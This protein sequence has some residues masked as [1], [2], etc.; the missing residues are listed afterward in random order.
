MSDH[1]VRWLSRGLPT[2]MHAAQSEGDASPSGLCNT[3]GRSGITATR[4]RSAVRRFRWLLLAG[5]IFAGA[6]FAQSADMVLAQHVVTPDPV[7]AGGVA[8]IT[9]T[10]NNNGTS[11]AANVQLTDTI[12]A[13]STFVSMTASNG[14]TCTAVA[15]YVCTWATIPFPGSRTVTLRVTLPTAAVWTNSAALTSDTADNNT[16]NNSL[17]R[18]ITVV[19]AANLAVSATSS[20]GGP[21]AAGT[22]YNYAVTVTNNG[23]PDPLPAGQSPRVT[24]NVPTG[25][26]VTSRPTG[27]GWDCQPSSGYPLTAPAG[28]GAGTEIT[29]SRSDGLASGASFPNI[30]VPAVANV[31]GSVDATFDVRSNFPDG[32]TSDNVDTETVTLTA[33]TDMAI[34]K[35]AALAAGGGGSQATF[36]LAA[37]QLGGSPPTGVTVTDTLPAGLDYVSHSAAAPWVCDFGAT[38]AGRLTCT[39]PGTYIGGPFT[40][41][42]AI[43]LVANVSGI[44]DIPNTGTVAANEADSN[45]ANN[46]ST[47]TVNNSADLRISKSPSVNPVVTGAS[48]DWNIVVRNF[49]PMPVLTGQ[50][51]T[52]TETVPAGMSLAALPGGSQWSCA[53]LPAVGPTTVTCTH[54]RSS[55]LAVNSD[56]PTLSIPATNTNAG[57]L[58]NNVCLALSGGGP[59]EAGDTP[60]F[61]RNCVGAGITGTTGVNSADLQIVKNASPGSVVVGQNLTYT[62]VATNLS[63]TVDATNVHVYDTVNNLVSTG[64]LQSITTTQG[65]CSPAGPYPLNGVSQ[66]VDC[67][68]G[69]L[70]RNGGSATIVIT[71]RPNNATAAVLARGN[72]ATVNSLDVGDPDRSN[73]SSTVSSNVEP[74]VDATVTKTVNPSSNVRVGQPTVYTVTARNGGPSRANELI[75]TDVM[76]PNT[77]FVSVGT[78]SNSGTCSTVPAVNAVGGTLSCRWTNVDAN[79][80]RT[81]T[82]TVRPLAAALGTTISNTVNVTVGAGD[83]E[84][85]TTN[86]SSTITTNVIDSLVDIL[87]QKTDS[88]D[89]VALGAETMYTVTIRNAGPSIG[90]NLVMTD[91]F[92]NAGNTARFSY[93]GSL[94]ATVAGVNVPAPACTAPAIGAMSGTLQCTF[95]TIDVGTTEQ[96]VLTYRMRA[97]SIITAGS[98]SGTQGNRVTVAVAENETQTTNNTVDED[99]TTSR[100]APAAGSEIDLGI[101][102]TTSAARATPG[103]E[104]DYTLRVTNTQTAGSGRDVVPANGAQVTDALPAGLTF[105]SAPG[106]SYD[107]ASR[108]VVCVIASLAA[109]ASVDFTVR[110]RVDSPYAGPA[111]LSNTACVDMPADPVGG[112]NC[113]TTPKT[114]GTPPPT[115]IP[116]LSEWGMIL[117]SILLA[118]LALREV[119]LQRRR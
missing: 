102:K 114:V 88:V 70:L 38:V 93:Q 34:T 21:I 99:T 92:P 49:G 37:R 110:V 75:I 71:V 17:T 107:G 98:Y 67:D 90:T 31:T 63:T 80:N 36:T 23:G 27:T 43:S 101:A 19:A 13:G 57:T 87:V 14:G 104:F 26:T 106:C 7:P 55:N 84:T 42:P 30:T 105:V 74:R 108:Q 9:I 2:R 18:N 32:D 68:L 78:P 60:G 85:D 72:T 82:F 28:G 112:N 5:G 115:S 113:S 77:A 81:V 25:A 94:T 53:A 76:P 95:P 61:E 10:V 91:T 35:T 24:F 39:Y 83:T 100:A 41:L 22:P 46:T 117:L 6:A 64:G 3:A 103:T 58:T 29:C 48:Y 96:V 97:E 1:V 111:T 86:N 62:I 16:G 33:G 45:N 89:P 59:V 44:G 109:G 8:T 15:P 50:T 40:N 56:A 4:T 73:N 66:V 20:A 54:T 65:S 118:S 51:I 79:S 47:V 11:S 116:T 69:T 12:P 52:V 119:A